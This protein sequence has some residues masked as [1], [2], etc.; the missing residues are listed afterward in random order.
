MRRRNL[1]PCLRRFF[2]GQGF[3][4]VCPSGVLVQAQWVGGY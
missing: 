1:G 4:F 3:A 2:L